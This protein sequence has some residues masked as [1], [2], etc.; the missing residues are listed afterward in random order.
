MVIVF[1]LIFYPLVLG[2]VSH[3]TTQGIQQATQKKSAILFAGDEEAP[4][5]TQ[6]FHDNEEVNLILYSS[7]EKATE[8]FAERRGDLLVIVSRSEDEELQIGLKYR[9]WNQDSEMALARARTIL[10]DHFRAQM[11]RELAQMGLDSQEVSSPFT[12]EVESTGSP[13]GNLGQEMIENML[14]YFVV[15]AIITAAMG[16]G[17]EITAGE[18]ERKTIS[19][20]LASQL[21]RTQIVL[22]KFIA[23]FCVA[24]AGA[25]FAV[26][27]L[28][29]GLGF[30]GIDMEFG[31]LTPKLFGSIVLTLLPLVAVLSCIVIIVGTFARTQKEANIYQTPIYM[32]VIL[33]GILSMSGGIQLEGIS[34]LIPV[35]NSLEVFKALLGGTFN[36]H[37]LAL[38][39]ASN[40]F[41]GG[42]LLSLSVKLFNKENVVF[43]T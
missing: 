2:L 12:L 29:Y 14:P 39:F 35:I 23:V 11:E 1:P 3:Y 18:K 43:R 16:L 25:V 26:L 30:F 42:L 10:E 7:S 22:G 28:V 6:S 13:T 36:L 20:L 41:L 38:T 40:I 15:L 21:S 33:T 34:F 27:G 8:D 24:S 32:T 4:Q 19:T 17:A 9:K 37:H 5:L 31:Q